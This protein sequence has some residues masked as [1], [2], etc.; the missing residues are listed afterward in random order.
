MS[1]HS[2]PQRLLKK[3]FFL[4]MKKTK[5]NIYPLSNLQLG[6]YVTTLDVIFLKTH[7]GSSTFPLSLDWETTELQK[8]YQNLQ[9]IKMK[10]CP[11]CISDL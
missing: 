9:R 3:I 10:G 8:N 5:M 4:K 11:L 1:P 2:A 6:S 7:S